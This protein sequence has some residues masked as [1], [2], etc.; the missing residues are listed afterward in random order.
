MPYKDKEKQKQFQADWHLKTKVDR[1]ELTSK[2]KKALIERNKALIAEERLKGCQICGYNKC[3]AAL[4]FHHLDPN[5]KDLGLAKGV[6]NWGT[7]R[8]RE[9][10]AKCIVVCARCHREIH[11]NDSN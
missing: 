11:Y 7:E 9:E 4:D 6:R 2:S 5:S 3:P 8:L 10:I 1:K